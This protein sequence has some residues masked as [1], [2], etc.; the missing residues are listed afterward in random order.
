MKARMTGKSVLCRQVIAGLAFGSFLILTGCIADD[1]VTPRTSFNYNDVAWAT[2]S[3][4]NTV[5]GTGKMT[6]AEGKTY[7]C[8]YAWLRPDSAYGREVTT[9]M[10]GST[11]SAVVSRRV[12]PQP[13]MFQEYREAA[14]L[15][16]ERCEKNGEFKFRRIPDGIWYVSTH[17]G[18]IRDTY[19]V[20][21]RIEVRGNTT[22]TVDLP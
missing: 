2:K 11:E 14:T 19:A 9:I 15:R 18:P 5:V 8:D 3:G 17:L 1:A 16:D 22:V 12:T 21:K 13:V 10:F 20:M 7:V 4:G 6:T